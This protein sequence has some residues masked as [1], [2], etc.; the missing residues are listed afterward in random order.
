[1][2]STKT[3]ACTTDRRGAGAGTSAVTHVPFKEKVFLYVGSSKDPEERKPES[4][5]TQGDRIFPDNATAAG[6]LQWV[7]HELFSICC[8]SDENL[9][10]LQAIGFEWFRTTY[11]GSHL[12]CNKY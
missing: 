3:K 1:M 12:T 2:N 8:M 6:D 9:R 10:M 7:A 11:V 4:I 5:Q